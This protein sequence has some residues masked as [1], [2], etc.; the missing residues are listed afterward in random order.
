MLNVGSIGCGAGYLCGARAPTTDRVLTSRL[1]KHLRRSA[2]LF[3]YGWDG[4]ISKS[5]FRYFYLIPDEHC[6]R[7]VT[8]NVCFGHGFDSTSIRRGFSPQND[9]RCLMKAGHKLPNRPTNFVAVPVAITE[10][11]SP[12]FR[13]IK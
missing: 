3:L 10:E 5:D 13:R 12:T 11:T 4:L 9:V 8:Q 1:D 7:T 6:G 2:C